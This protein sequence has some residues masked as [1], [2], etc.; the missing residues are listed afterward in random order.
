MDILKARGIWMLIVGA[1]VGVALVGV[2]WQRIR[3]AAPL[4]GP[5]EARAAERAAPTHIRAEGHLIPYPGAEVTVGTDIGGTLRSF[6]LLEK[7]EAQKGDLVAEVDSSEQKAAYAEAR[8]RALEAAVDIKL[9]ELE[10]RRSKNLFSASAVAEDAVDRSEHDLAGALA[11]KESATATTGRLAATLA[12]T[13]IVAPIHGVVMSRKA[14]AG[15]TVPA[16]A[17]LL[18]LCD[19]TRTRIEAEV[20]EYDA[21]RVAL[22]AEA[23]IR[24]EGVD[25]RAYKGKVEEIPDSVTSRR[26]KPQDPGRPIDTRVLLVKIALLEGTP[27]KLG[28][29]V[30][31]EIKVP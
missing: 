6:P 17:Q 4:A 7:M 24:V 14:E 5:A 11:K 27:I 8:A 29:R 1:T 20:D 10:L 28:Q 2:P 3:W 18:T 30:E 25:G 26:I 21:A 15:E 31:V 23:T 22:G 12:K 16:G 13:R 19:L 9:Y